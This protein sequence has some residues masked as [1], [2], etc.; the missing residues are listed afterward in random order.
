MGVISVTVWWKLSIF[1][2]NAF[3]YMSNSLEHIYAENRHD[4]YKELSK[5]FTVA[6]LSNG[7]D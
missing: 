3:F 4:I 7:E 5:S 2:M 1:H 6:L